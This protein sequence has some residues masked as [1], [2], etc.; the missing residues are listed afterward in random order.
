MSTTVAENEHPHI[1]AQK[2]EE[3][4]IRFAGDSGDGMQLTGSQFSTTS[5]LMGNDL[6][7]LPDFPAEIRAP[8]GTLPGVSA[9]QVRIADYDIHTPG[10]APDVLVAMNPAAL[11]K[12]LEDLKPNGVII[13]NLDEFNARNLAKAGYATNPLEDHSLDKYRVF[14]AQIGTM[15]RRALEGSGLDNKSQERCKNFF[16]LGMVYWLF[17]RPLDASIDFLKKTFVKKPELA[18]ANIKSL[19]AGWNFCDIT[20]L[21]QVRY[22]VDPATLEP[23]IY[24]SIHGNSALA[25]G[26]VAAARQSGLPLFLG[27]Y[28]ITPASDILHQLSGY[29]NFGVTT[30]QAEDEIAAMCATIGAAFGGALAVTTTSGPGIALKSEAM[31]LAIQVELPVVICDIQRGGPST[32][33]PTKTEQSDL[34]QVMFGRNGDS[35]LVV[36]APSSPK[37]CFDMAIEACR[38]ALKYMVPVV[39]LSDGYIANGSEPWKLPEIV[40]L[41]QL[42]PAFR[43]DPEGFQPYQREEATLARPWAVPGTPG[44]EHRI[45]GLEKEEVTGN[46]SYD[47]HNHERMVHLRAEKVAR[48]ADDIPALEVFG[49]ETGELLVLG[50]GS[51]A[52]SITAAVNFARRDGL[53]VS[54]AH[55]RHLN[56]F[57]KNL[58]EVLRRFDRV[59]LPEMNMG[60][61]ALLIRARYLKDILTFSK[62]QGRPFTRTEIY[63]KIR[64]IL[65]PVAHVN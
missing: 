2:L 58:G 62:V 56:P 33:L 21:F 46:V 51:T 10:D 24:R 40:D 3:V 31:N 54:R 45:G 20:G 64:E 17:S 6:S 7:T 39:L 19:K 52:G 23:G 55:L 41:P 27:A 37:D 59:L 12:E 63:N 61:L 28:P 22:E 16:A 60:Q 32:G 48:I 8:Q 42:K 30:F 43:T 9:F 35:P 49:D 25:I 38:I 15:N 57:P 5:A 50:W 26:L 13:V 44:L 36:V 14:Q 47:P 4:V 65:E 53:S 29:K 34:L 18:E 1:E 11:K